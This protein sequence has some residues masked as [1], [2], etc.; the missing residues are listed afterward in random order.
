VL[1]ASLKKRAA[2]PENRKRSAKANVNIVAN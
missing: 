2:A 1:I